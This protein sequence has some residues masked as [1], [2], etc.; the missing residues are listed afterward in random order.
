MPAPLPV[1]VCKRVHPRSSQTG[2]PIR[3]E[4]AFGPL[5]TCEV[6]SGSDLSFT[7]PETI[8]AGTTIRHGRCGKP[9]LSSGFRQIKEIIEIRAAAAFRYAVAAVMAGERAGGRC[10]S[11][12]ERF[13][14][15]QGPGHELLAVG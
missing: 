13:V 14:D 12:W 7:D 9:R 4:F 15:Y 5:T 11:P 8:P 3:L 2:F 6:E 10:P 1:P